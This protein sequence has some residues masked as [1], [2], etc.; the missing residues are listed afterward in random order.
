MSAAAIAAMIAPESAEEL[1]PVL[2]AE[3]LELEQV[4]LVVEGGGSGEAPPAAAIISPRP[5]C[6]WAAWR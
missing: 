5:I 3:A 4:T 1:A 2:A 6:N